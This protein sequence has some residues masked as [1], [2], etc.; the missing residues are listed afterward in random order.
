MTSVSDLAG[1]LGLKKH[2]KSWRGACPSCG[3]SGAFS[4]RAGRDR[5]L[6]YCS[7]GCDRDTLGSTVAR[8]AGGEWQP[9]ERDTTGDDAA[10]RRRQAAALRMLERCLPAAGT[11]AD[12]YLMGRG[13][14]GLAASPAL[15]FLAST[16]HPESGT[17]PAMIAAVRDSTGA[18][19]AAHR[20]FLDPATARK[21]AVTPAKA[22]LG[23][24]WG[25]AIRLHP[26]A[27]ELVIG[28]GI[29]TAASAG[30]LLGLP[31]WAAISAGNLARG[32][33]LPP[34]VRSVVIATDADPAGQDAARAAWTRWTAEGRKVRI[35]TPDRPGA[36]FNDILM[37]AHRG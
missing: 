33:V 3:Y 37:E 34:E 4:V 1:R 21:A 23:P 25:G 30:R 12:R 28:E 16:P 15:H 32:L 31:A 11:L 35:A 6:L 5:P 18:V 7:N 10:R 19:V 24:V 20:T 27:A 2:P 22:S 36:D 13:L 26:A 17:Y 8:I 29:E 9:P 14:A